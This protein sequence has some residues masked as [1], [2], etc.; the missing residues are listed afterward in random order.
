MRWNTACRVAEGASA[1]PVGKGG[2]IWADAVRD[3]GLAELF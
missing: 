1:D 3:G 2:S